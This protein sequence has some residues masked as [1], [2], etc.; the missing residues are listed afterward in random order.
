MAVI[1]DLTA[2]GFNVEK[3]LDREPHLQSGALLIS[4]QQDFQDAES[5]ANLDCAD[6]REAYGP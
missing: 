2:A 6:R 5:R 3:L 4:R 1:E